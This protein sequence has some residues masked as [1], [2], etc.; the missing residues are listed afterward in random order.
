MQENGELK[1]ELPRPK[2][3]KSVWFREYDTAGARDDRLAQLYN[4]SPLFNDIREVLQVLY[5]ESKTRARGAV[6][7]NDWAMHI[8]AEQRYR[9]ALEDVAK[10]LPKFDQD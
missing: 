3:I 1:D 7:S 9:D 8:V 5:N 4:N 6:D 10:M 2:G